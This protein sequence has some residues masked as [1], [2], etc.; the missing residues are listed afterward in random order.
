MILE[1][2]LC[3]FSGSIILQELKEFFKT[4]IKLHDFSKSIILYD[5]MGLGQGALKLGYVVSRIL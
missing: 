4:N 5:E 3:E 2:E 1:Q